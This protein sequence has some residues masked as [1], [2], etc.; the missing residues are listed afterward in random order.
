GP[1]AERGDLGDNQGR[2][3]HPGQRPG[4]PARESRDP[5][6]GRSAGEASL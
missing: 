2:G 3:S 4:A 5:R 1:H 6:L